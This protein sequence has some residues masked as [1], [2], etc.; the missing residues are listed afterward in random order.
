MIDDNTLAWMLSNHANEGRDAMEA[1]A[2]MHRYISEKIEA[3]DPETMTD[4]EARGV[5]RWLE[6][7]H[8]QAPDADFRT[9]IPRE[10]ENLRD[11]ALLLNDKAL[12]TRVIWAVDTFEKWVQRGL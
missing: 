4:E 10:F 11:L 12:L 1:L 7:I 8:A 3:L 2:A 5:E 9:G 6:L